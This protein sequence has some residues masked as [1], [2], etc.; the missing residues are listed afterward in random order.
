MVKLLNNAEY[1]EYKGKEKF[2]LEK[3]GKVMFNSG[4]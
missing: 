3:L 4:K 1:P 2:I